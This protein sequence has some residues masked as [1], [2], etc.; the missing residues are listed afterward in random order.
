MTVNPGN[1]DR[2]TFCDGS[3]AIGRLVLGML[4]F[5]KWSH[6]PSSLG[7]GRSEGKVMSGYGEL[8]SI[9][10]AFDL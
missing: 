3:L 5:V 4:A 7:T 9:T 6:A 10:S 8:H 2:S 1:L